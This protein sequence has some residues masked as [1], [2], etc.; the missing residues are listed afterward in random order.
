MTRRLTH[1]R[2]RDEV[3]PAARHARL[4]GEG[5]K[6]ALLI[7]ASIAVLAGLGA[8]TCALTR[9]SGRDPHQPRQSRKTPF[10]QK[11]I[12]ID[13]LRIRYIEE[14]SGPPIVLI[15]GH[16]SRI[17]EY[18]RLTA[19]LRTRHRVIVLDLPGS[20]YSSKPERNYD[21]RFYEDV[22][23]RFLDAMRIE[24]SF[25]AGGSLG[26]NLA[27]RLAHREPKRF[28]RVAAW[29]PGGA[30][31]AK[32]A[33]AGFMRAIEC[34]CLFWP[35]VKIQS[36]YWY[37]KSWPGADAALADTSVYYHEVVSPGFVRMY[38]DVAADQVG[39]S[40]FDIADGIEQ[41]ALLMWGDNDHGMGMDEGIRRLRALMPH[42]E[43]FVVKGAGHALAPERPEEVAKAL[44][45]FF[46]RSPERL[47]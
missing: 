42:S 38:W 27:L 4:K 9:S 2:A 24:R 17:E 19:L 1:G 32:P 20:G 14:G 35:T 22:V 43:L 40:L 12:W 45:E 31:R 21:L 8:L 7:V 36:S 6:K 33:L 29:S 39:Q 28:P 37:S 11:E 26:G 16:T 44:L 10:I 46:S 25:L 18:D 47:P 30:W 3:G 13:G 23:L 41:P 34:E 15:P 5:M